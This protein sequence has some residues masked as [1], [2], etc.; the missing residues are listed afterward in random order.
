MEKQIKTFAVET[1]SVDPEAGI[2]E[3]MLSTE[4]EDRD[5]DVLLASGGDASN[6]LKNPVV[7][8]GHNYGDPNA[9]VAKALEITS[10]PGVGIKLVFQFLERGISQTADLVRALWDQKF[11]NAMSI[12]FIPKAFEPRP[13]GGLIFTAFEIL[14]GS[15]VTI[16]ANASALRLALDATEYSTKSGRV[17]SAANEGKIRRAV[18]T[19]TE[20]LAQLDKADDE[21]GKWVF[22][23]T[24]E[25]YEKAE[26]MLDDGDIVGAQRLIFEAMDK[27]YSGSDPDTD[28]QP[29]AT[30]TD[31]PTGDALELEEL[32][33]DQFDE[34][35]Q[36][37]GEAIKLWT[38]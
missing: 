14:E 21:E 33:D 12:G 20:V 8:F 1:K 4:A 13:E 38:P 23:L 24:K 26:A 17:L 22:G 36:G 25:L 16:P 28:V 18:E 11:L 37:I 29:D 3:A 9:I 10:I 7:L 27:E 6:Y 2:Y 32:T 34:M 31:A 30:H 15:I 5:G 35:L 19:L